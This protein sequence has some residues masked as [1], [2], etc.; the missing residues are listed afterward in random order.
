MF[1]KL[2]NYN[3]THH[4]M[5]YL[6]GVNNLDC[7]INEINNKGLHF[8]DTDHWTTFYNK[9]IKYYSIVESWDVFFKKENG[10]YKSNQI[11]L[12]DFLPIQNLLLLKSQRIDAI[13]SNINILH[14]FNSEWLQGYEILEYIVYNNDTAIDILRQINVFVP[15]YIIIESLKYFGQ[16]GK[17]LDD[18]TRKENLHIII[19]TFPREIFY[20]K[21]T[22]LPSD[23]ILE[24]VRVDIFL[25]SE[26]REFYNFN[27]YFLETLI[28]AHPIM[29]LYILT[30]FPDRQLELK[31]IFEYAIG[32]EKSWKILVKN[33]IVKI[34]KQKIK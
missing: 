34:K 7:D 12:S 9:N 30:E 27:N 2:L 4:D 14:V 13:K 19:K 23:I 17:Y 21:V 3:F 10:H 26:L 20:Y 29:Y 5:K 28:V 8:T 1:I 25:L 18:F 15:K 16:N 24:S 33:K 32:N 11:T 6:T 22:D 31:E